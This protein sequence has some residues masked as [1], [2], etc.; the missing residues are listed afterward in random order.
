M[1]PSATR[2]ACSL[3]TGAICARLGLVRNDSIHAEQPDL[4][5]I[6]KQRQAENENKDRDKG[7]KSGHSMTAGAREP[8]KGKGEVIIMSTTTNIDTNMETGTT[9]TAT[10]KKHDWWT[11]VGGIALA[12]LGV[13]V[14]GAPDLTL[15]TLAMA[16]GIVLAIAG[17][18]EIISYFVYKSSGTVSGWQIVGGICN[19]ILAVIFLANP[20][21]TAVL[22]PWIAGVGI[23]AYGIF[24]IIGGFQMRSALPSSW[25]W[26]VANGIVAILCGILFWVFPESLAL[27]LAIFLVFR[28][29][30]MIV[31][32]WGSTT[33]T[34]SVE[35]E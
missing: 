29:I 34:V 24:S 35:Q 25:G 28:G 23:A 16:V 8:D 20:V 4:T 18:V 32:G 21:L 11:I 10:V 22:L 26:F 30:T 33:T 12:A 9:T 13:F 3:P 15:L 1:F 14:F 7:K 6:Q 19:I 31:F 17:V 27:Y 2:R 5:Q